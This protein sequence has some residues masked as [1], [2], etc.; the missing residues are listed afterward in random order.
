MTEQ[1]SYL[2]YL[3]PVLWQDEPAAPEFSL[4]AMLRI[5]EKIADRHRRRRAAVRRMADHEDP[6]LID[7]RSP[8]LHQL[9]DPWTDTGRQRS[10]SCPGSPPGWRWS[11][12]RCRST[13][14]WDEY[15]RRKVTAQIA[16]IYRLRGP[17]GRPEPV[18]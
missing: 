16:Q 14:L 4:G 18:P 17:Q 3:P 6:P 9:F 7:P 13:P 12:R 5:F 1:S 2:R 11:S 10:P 8:D 15:Q